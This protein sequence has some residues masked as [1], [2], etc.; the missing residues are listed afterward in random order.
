MKGLRILG[1]RSL[2][3][4]KTW[5]LSLGKG[6]LEGLR[7]KSFHCLSSM[8]RSVFNMAAYNLAGFSSRLL[9]DVVFL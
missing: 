6:V 5:Q 3:F 7:G 4:R 8:N 9:L 2:G 1:L